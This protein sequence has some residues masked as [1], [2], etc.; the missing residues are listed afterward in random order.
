MID[1]DLLWEAGKPEV[2]LILLIGVGAVAQA[3][4]PRFSSGR[5]AIATLVKNVFVPVSVVQ[6]EFP[7]A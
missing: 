3:K 7:L 5:H 1:V 4:V 2:K 6:F